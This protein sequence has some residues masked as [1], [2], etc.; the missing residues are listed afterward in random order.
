MYFSCDQDQAA[1]KNDIRIHEAPQD[2]MPI[3][4]VLSA[5][6]EFATYGGVEGIDAFWRQEALDWAAS[7]YGCSEAAIEAR[8]DTWAKSENCPE[9][10][11]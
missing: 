8:N 3:T 2:K 1:M 5:Y 7:D 6:V 4:E 11:Q 10:A 9:W